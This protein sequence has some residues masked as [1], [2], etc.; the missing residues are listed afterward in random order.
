MEKER[1]EMERFDLGVFSRIQ[2]QSGRRVP[3]IMELVTQ[4]VCAGGAVFES[5]F[6]KIF[7]LFTTR[8]ARGT[9]VTEACL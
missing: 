6:E 7:K 5:P 9:E 2:V 1:R 4:N 3:E 8:C